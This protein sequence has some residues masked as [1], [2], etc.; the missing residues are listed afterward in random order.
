MVT[1]HQILA[2][3]ILILYTADSYQ[4]KCEFSNSCG[5]GGRVEKIWT[6]K[7]DKIKVKAI[8][9]LLPSS[10]NWLTTVPG[11]IE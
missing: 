11:L 6:L 1:I 7:E 3:L 8:E 10:T 4:T 5:V 2:L 9:L